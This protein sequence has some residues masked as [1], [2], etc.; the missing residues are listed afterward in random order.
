M[1]PPGKGPGLE[2]QREFKGDAQPFNSAALD[3]T[4]YRFG[5]WQPKISERQIT[6][7]VALGA[8]DLAKNMPEG[9]DQG[10]EMNLDDG[11]LSL[12]KPA[13]EARFTPG[14]GDEGFT[15]DR[16]ADESEV[17]I[18][19]T[20]PGENASLKEEPEGDHSQSR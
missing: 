17:E 8:Q 12:A 1:R 20:T 7:E 18:I 3:L 16:S 14:S 9:A 19:Q 13:S 15:C 11:S 5:F 4:R 10:V 2:F 6:E